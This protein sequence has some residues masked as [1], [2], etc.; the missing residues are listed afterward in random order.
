MFMEELAER[1]EKPTF[2]EVVKLAKE[3]NIT[4]PDQL[5]RLYDQILDLWARHKDY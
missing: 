1:S 3:M 4:S 2:E 5:W